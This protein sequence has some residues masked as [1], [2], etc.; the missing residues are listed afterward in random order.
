MTTRSTG[1]A[2][3]LPA[4]HLSATD[5]ALLSGLVG[6]ADAEGAAGLLQQ[7]LARAHV[8]RSGRR[9]PTVGL[10]HWVHYVDGDNSRTRR[11]KIVLPAEADIDQGL[12]SPLSHVGAG[13]L[14]L[15]Q[16]QS[17]RWPA[18]SGQIRTLTPVLIEDPDDLV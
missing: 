7:E 11:I 4:I 10:N 18:P 15:A 9:I 3:R 13:L 12:I 5:H 17:I 14:G 8:H 16:G 6:D 2:P 1:A